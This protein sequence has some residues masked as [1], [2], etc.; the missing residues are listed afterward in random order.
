MIK[1]LVTISA[2]LAFPFFPLFNGCSFYSKFIDKSCIV[3]GGGP[4]L[5]IREVFFDYFDGN[6]NKIDNLNRYSEVDLSE[7][8]SLLIY[9]ELKNVGEPSI[10]VKVNKVTVKSSLGDT[11][12]SFPPDNN[13]PRELIKDQAI[14]LRHT[15]L[16]SAPYILDNLKQH[17]DFR[18]IVEPEILYYIRGKSQKNFDRLI[19]CSNTLA[20]TEVK[21]KPACSVVYKD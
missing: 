8:K 5:G 17:K 6:G 21:F 10:V 11:L 7:V 16:I 2:L 18:I 19:E 4:Q 20:E 14:T 13:E 12:E 3:R 15:G 9:F 1:I